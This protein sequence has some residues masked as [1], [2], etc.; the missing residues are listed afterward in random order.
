M[1]S[2]DLTLCTV[3][4]PF[5]DFIIIKNRFPDPCITVLLSG[6]STYTLQFISR[7]LT[8]YEDDDVFKVHVKGYNQEFYKFVEATVYIFTRK[9]I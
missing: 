9:I 7:K 3:F 4:L 2:N 6:M 5:Y 1:I 8:L